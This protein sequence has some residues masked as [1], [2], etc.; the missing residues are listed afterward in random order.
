MEATSGS[1]GSAGCSTTPEPARAHYLSSHQQRE[2]Q[3]LVT[4]DHLLHLLQR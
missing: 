4:R 1:S 3:Q 2:G